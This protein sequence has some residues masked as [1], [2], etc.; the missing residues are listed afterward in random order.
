MGGDCELGELLSRSPELYA[1][2]QPLFSHSKVTS[3]LVISVIF[4]TS[5][6][7]SPPVNPNSQPSNC[8][9]LLANL[10]LHLQTS[11][12]KSNSSGAE[13]MTKPI[14]A[15]VVQTR[16]HGRDGLLNRSDTAYSA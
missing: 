13:M 1:V 6:L 4:M 15:L 2:H 12:R 5:T 3:H 7:N 16:E 8:K 11:T 9:P 10:H 14:G